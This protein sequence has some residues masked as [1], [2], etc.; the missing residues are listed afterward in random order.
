MPKIFLIKNR[1]HQQQLRLL[2]L[3]NKDDDHH[4]HRLGPLS[5]T[6][7]SSSS[8]HANNRHAATAFGGGGRS[9]PP[10]SLSAIGGTR[11]DRRD[12][13]DDSQHSNSNDDEP[14]SLVAPR[15]LDTN[16]SESGEQ[17]DG[18]ST[19]CSPTHRT[20]TQTDVTGVTQLFFSHVKCA[21]KMLFVDLFP[22][23]IWVLVCLERSL[24]RDSD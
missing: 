13:N 4:H 2:E 18:I 17:N 21:S 19:M 12:V 6:A 24:L 8:R 20:T 3:G 1:L 14:L 15:K 7:A 16:R 9:S 10:T 23:R 22:F 5:P 11:T